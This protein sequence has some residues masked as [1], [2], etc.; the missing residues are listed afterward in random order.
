M[1]IFI[2]C[3]ILLDVVFSKEPFYQTSSELLNYLETKGNGFIA[4]HSISNFYYLTSH[5][6]QQSKLFI[7]EVAAFLNLVPLSNQELAVALELTFEDFEDSLQCAL[8]M[9][10]E[11]DVIISRHAKN[12]DHSPVLTLTPEAFLKSLQRA[13]A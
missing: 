10:C 6:K 13:I 11:A 8:A 5:N 1:N 4:A 2:D 9:S 3:D 12:Y 7:S